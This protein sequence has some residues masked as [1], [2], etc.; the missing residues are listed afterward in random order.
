MLPIYLTL[1][2]FL[3]IWLAA[4][5]GLSP[6]PWPWLGGGG[7]LLLL[8]LVGERRVNLGWLAYV[9]MVGLGC[10]RFLLAQPIID[11]NHIAYYNNSG[12]LIL[13]GVVIT[14]PDVRDRSTNLR[15]QVE[16]LQLPGGL[17]LPVT[18]LVLVQAPRFPETTYGD[19]LEIRGELRVPPETADF[20][21]REYLAR[22]GIHSLVSFPRLTVLAH[23]QGSPFRHLILTVKGQAQA[24]ISQIIREPQA[25]LLTGI[26]LGNDKGLSPQ[27]QQDFR[28]TGMTHIIAISGFNIMLLV[29]VLL[30]LF[31]PLA[32]RQYGAILAAIGIGL[33]AILVGGDASVMRATIM[34]MV[35]LFSTRFLG[36]ASFPFASLF[37]AGL[38]MTLFNP[39]TLW[40]VGFQLS[41]M[42]TLGLMLYAEPFSQAAKN[43]VSRYLDEKTTQGVI[44]LLSDA[45]LV[46]LA[47]QVLT[48]PLMMAYFG[49]LSLVSLVANMLILPVQPAVLVWGGLATLVG[50][51]LPGVGQMLGW[52]A[53]LCL[54]YTITLVQ[55]LAQ[56]PAAAVPISLSPTG[57]FLIYLLIFGPTWWYRQA[58]E[59]RERLWEG[60]QRNLNQKIAVTATLV[61]AVLALIAGNSQPDGYL[62]LWFFDVGQGDAIFIQT[63]SGRQ[64][65]IDGGL[66]PS[67]LQEELGRR[68]PF[69]DRTL[70]I[71]IAT[72]P[73]ADH[74]AGLPG[75]WGRYRVG[76][77]IT[78]GSEWGAS[79][80][81]DALLQA[82]ADQGTPV[83][84]AYV[85]ETIVIGDG[86]RLEILHPGAMLNQSNRNENSVSVRLV[87]GKMKILL[88]GD[89]EQAGEAAMLQSGRDLQS[90][91]FKAGHH[92]SE[93]SSGSQFLAAA[94]PQIVVVSA[95]KDNRYGHPHR[96]LLDRVAGQGAALLR[97]DELGTIE[98]VS[99]GELVWIQGYGR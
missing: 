6:N 9:G 63:P 53:W 49:Q 81:F 51:V 88:T 15:L 65:L 54:W 17:T 50:M 76:Q 91:L 5:L 20:S 66:Y 79:P 12:Q 44:S 58:P 59:R 21:Y 94:R 93:T 74:V 89:A 69:W 86:V 43:W 68:M 35:Y 31:E 61:L 37:A 82:A 13:T 2:W 62:H 97:T 84:R 78:D 80:V 96:D 90:F 34:G 7:V 33:Y 55:A 27:L 36:R 4:Q 42:A 77:L 75:V 39:M 56:V 52:V 18:G 23:E 11:Q 47:A 67:V 16:T 45:V 41:F 40:D 98:I 3:G 48:L 99:D 24:T 25:A 83:H 8:G 95:G 30:K 92:G 28:T 14:E 46:T 85:G 22:Q 29:G 57:V 26:L 60:I 10:G 73:D 72:H 19:R 38:L 71:V 70:D 1:C 64:I 32:G 87:Y